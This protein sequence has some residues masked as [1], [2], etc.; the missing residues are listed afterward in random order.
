[1]TDVAFPQFAGYGQKTAF[2]ITTFAHS[3][4]SPRISQ[5]NP[6]YFHYLTYFI[7]CRDVI[8][9]IVKLDD[10]RCDRFQ[11]LAFD[12]RSDVVCPWFHTLISAYR[13]ESGK[14][15]SSTIFLI[16]WPFFHPV[17][18]SK[19]LWTSRSTPALWARCAAFHFQPTNVL[20]V[21]TPA[22]TWLIGYLSC[23]D[24]SEP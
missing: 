24:V 13:E 12:C 8:V 6:H 23:N 4:T 22:E 14:I 2:N 16:Y 10:D 15:Y 7:Y 5:S 1:M 17:A 19:G 20:R 3:P 9:D 18:A 21:I 11:M